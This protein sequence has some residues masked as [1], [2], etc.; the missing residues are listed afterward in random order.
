[1]EQVAVMHVAAEEGE[2]RHVIGE[3]D[4]LAN[5]LP[6]GRGHQ[7]STLTYGDRLALVPRFADIVA[8]VVERGWIA[9][10]EPYYRDGWQCGDPMTPAALRALRDPQVWV[11]ADAG[12]TRLIWLEA[13]D[14]WLDLSRRP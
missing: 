13:T 4:L 2:L 1:M 12:P 7:P 5:R 6:V 11:L 10:R 8:D 3:W 14:Y 9:V